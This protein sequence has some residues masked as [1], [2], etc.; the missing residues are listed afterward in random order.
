[1]QP[2]KIL[3]ANVPADG[4][5][6]PLTRL[7]VFLKDQ[8]HDVRWYTQEFY[9]NKI[10]KLDIEY[11]PFVRPPQLNQSNFENYFTERK[12][13]KSQISKLRFDLENVFIRRSM[14]YYKD[15]EDIYNEFPFDLMIADVM[16]TV[17]PFV[18]YKLNVPVIAVGVVPLAETSKGLPP[19][20]LGITPSKGISGK[21]KNAF[22]KFFVNKVV[23]GKAN[24]LFKSLLVKEGIEV[25]SF[26]N[27][28][29][30]LYRSSDIVLQSGTPG[31]EYE[32]SDMS[33]NIRFA[34]PLLP[35]KTEFSKTY[36]LPYQYRKFKRRVLVTQG[37]VEKD[38]EKLIV[39]TLQ[40]FR[41]TDTL[42]IVTTGGSRTQ[43]LKARFPD[44]NFIIE[45]YIPFNDVMPYCDVYVTNGGYGGVMLGIE[46]RLPM[47]VAGVHE[48]KNEINA[49]VGYFKLGINLKKE[50][51][52]AAELRGAIE[53][54]LAD[55]SF[56]ENVRRLS[57]EFSRYEP[58]MTLQKCFAEIFGEE[59]QAIYMTHR[60]AG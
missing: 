60:R 30:L 3:F 19:S 6:N 58:T 11:Y 5:F 49:R 42:V 35:Y 32:R 9:K 10:E 12:K 25:Q 1:M 20:G 31:F 57:S 59:Q 27:M 53:Q 4:H 23:F 33:K 2:K 56:K 44:E 7:A 50:T 29:D 14:E 48:G 28:F 18:K 17:I 16:S 40:A 38:P 46:N 24:K 36:Y 21:I 22:L 45:D 47:V 41:N 8:G 26:G 43:E 39:P 52:S 13:C 37:T 55:K 51:P 15:I 54:V 34:G